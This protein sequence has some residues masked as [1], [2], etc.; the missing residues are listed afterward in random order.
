MDVQVSKDMLNRID[1]AKGEGSRQS[2]V[3]RAI[4]QALEVEESLEG[5]NERTIYTGDKKIT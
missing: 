5:Q 1:E 3:R 2:F 4:M